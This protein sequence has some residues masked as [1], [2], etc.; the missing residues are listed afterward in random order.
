[1]DVAIVGAGLAGL[2]AARDLVRR[3]LQVVVLEARDRVGGRIENATLSD[4]QYVE[5]GGQWIGPGSTSLQA[6]LDDF[7]LPTIGLPAKGN[8]MVRLRGQ[9]VAVPSK[10]DSTELTPFEVAD[11]GQGLQRLRRLAERAR[12]DQAWAEANKAWLDQDLRRWTQTNLRTAG[13]QRRF[14]EVYNATFGPMRP[15]ATLLE[16][17]NQVSSG[18]ETESILGA[19][20]GLNQ[21]RVDGG[22]YRL[23][24][25]IASELGEVVRLGCPVA[26]I[27]HEAQQAVLTLADG[28]QVAARRVISTLPPRLAVQQ[29]YDPPLPAWR[30]ETAC[31]VAAGNVI[32]AFLVYERPFWRDE[33]LSGQSSTDDGAVRVTFDTTTGADQHGLLMGFFEGAD[34][35]SLAKRSVTL[36]KRAFIDSV[37]QTFGDAAADP[38][39]YIERDWS[40]EEFTGG[41]HGAHFTPGIWMGFG[42]ALA[43]PEGVL[44]WAGAE[45]ATKGNGYMEGA[46]R[47]ATEVSAR[48]AAELA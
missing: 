40:T 19:N 45:Y 23:C 34:A 35:D 3:G 31:K 41:C 2:V 42:P 27:T 6:L 28:E 15:G 14:H 38:I 18:P 8:L 5:L 12:T 48:V 47:S 33:G 44:S 43:A 22:A 20:G 25:A 21:L 39:D 46:V 17:L 16:G 36:R 29:S 13:A 26:K 1:M 10:D 7:A 4:G 24:E 32:K 11:L 37:V 9:T 30:E